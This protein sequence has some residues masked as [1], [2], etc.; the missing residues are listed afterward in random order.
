LSEATQSR[1]TRRLLIE[2]ASAREARLAMTAR[3]K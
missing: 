2:I 3:K 1:A